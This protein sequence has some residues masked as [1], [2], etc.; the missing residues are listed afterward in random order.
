M[1]K[2]RTIERLYSLAALCGLFIVV[3]MVSGTLFYASTLN[4]V[5]TEGLIVVDA[6]VDS[7]AFICKL[8]HSK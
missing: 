7:K 4:E 1:F 6:W 8:L 5:M 2:Y 3:Y